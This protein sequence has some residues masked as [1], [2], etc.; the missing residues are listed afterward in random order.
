M[1]YCYLFIKIYE[2]YS[3]QE[4]AFLLKIINRYLYLNNCALIRRFSIL[5]YIYVFV[6]FYNRRL[7]DII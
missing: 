2:I 6:N 5:K 1:I 4:N 7:I 3:I